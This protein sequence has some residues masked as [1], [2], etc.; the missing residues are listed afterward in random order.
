[1]VENNR[2]HMYILFL[3]KIIRVC[4][5]IRSLSLLHSKWEKTCG[6][7]HSECNED[8]LFFIHGITITEYKSNK[9]SHQSSTN[10]QTGL[11]LC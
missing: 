5:L 2:N 8:I 4:F 7:G 11:D 1:M 10:V 3:P 6:F 9:G